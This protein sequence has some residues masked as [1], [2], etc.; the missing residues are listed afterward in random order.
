[1]ELREIE[2][3]LS[4]KET[5]AIFQDK[6]ELHF[7]STESI[8]GFDETLAGIDLDLLAF[9]PATDKDGNVIEKRK[10]RITP[11]FQVKVFEKGKPT[12]KLDLDDL[13][14]AIKEP[15]LVKCL[16]GVKKDRDAFDTAKELTAQAIEK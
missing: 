12:R 13:D 14:L 7:K 11:D 6:M 2:L 10:I 15:D 1:M 5:R 8:E 3:E 4:N 9:T 16:E